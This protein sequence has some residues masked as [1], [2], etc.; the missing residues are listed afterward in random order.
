MKWLLE[1]KVRHLRRRLLEDGL[2]EREARAYL[3]AIYRLRD[4]PGHLDF[5]HPKSFCDKANWLKLYYYDPLVCRCADKVGMRDYVAERVGSEFLVPVIGVYDSADAVDF[6]ALPNRFAMKVNW[7]SGQNIICAD[8]SKLDIEDARW[9]LAY[10]MRR[11][12]NHYFDGLEWGYRDIVPKIIVEEFLE[13]A[14]D[15]PDY[16]F[17]CF[18]GRPKVCAVV[19]GRNSSEPSATFYD[20]EYRTLPMT[21][22]GWRPIGRD[23]PKPVLWNRMLEAARTL[24]APFPHVRVD[25]YVPAEGE[26]KVGELTF[27][28][29]N[30]LTPHVPYE[31]DRKLGDMLK[32]PPKGEYRWGTKIAYKVWKHLDKRFGH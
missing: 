20:E 3:D 18:N 29:S 12:Q 17:Y 19:R 31:W 2:G 9:K 32:L 10:W 1:R 28:S 14:G 27:W 25:F 8:R 11:E 6:A 26:L 22:R 4:N 15:L 7:G 24:S 21:M 13:N 5:E 16:K 23:V 30:G